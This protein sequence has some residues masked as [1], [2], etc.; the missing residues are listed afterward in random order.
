MDFITNH[1]LTFILFIPA[2]AL[3][4]LLIH[5]EKTALIRWFTLIAADHSSLV[6]WRSFIQAAKIQ[7]EIGG[8]VP[9]IHSSYHLGVDGIALTM[10]I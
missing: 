4:L 8:M 7:F 5:K 1:L 6:V 3:I 10:V 9:A 2:A